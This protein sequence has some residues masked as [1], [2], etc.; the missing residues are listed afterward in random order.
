MREL[1]K[2]LENIK[3]DLALGYT[4]LFLLFTA[5]KASK[6]NAY[7]INVCFNISAYIFLLADFKFE[8]R[9]DV[10]FSFI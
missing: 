6:N 3:G 5:K 2:D 8:S 1:T 7:N 9:R 10:L 4:K